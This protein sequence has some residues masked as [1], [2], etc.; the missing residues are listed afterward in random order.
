MGIRPV[1]EGGPGG[2]VPPQQEIKLKLCP[3]KPKFVLADFNHICMANKYFVVVKLTYSS[4]VDSSEF[5]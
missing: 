2:A 1:A 3:T 4:E 5:T